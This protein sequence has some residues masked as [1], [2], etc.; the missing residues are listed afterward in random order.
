MVRVWLIAIL[1][2]LL[3][4]ASLKIDHVTVAGT[5]LK[6]MQA[7]LA[8]VG[9]RTVYGG[10]HSNHATEMA[11]VS[12]PDGGYLELIAVQPNAEAPRLVPLPDEPFETGLGNLGTSAQAAAACSSRSSFTM[13]RTA[14]SA[15]SRRASRSRRTSGA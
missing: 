13:S 10:A 3:T 8:A 12:F 7:D 6:K 11:L 5:S 14:S 15:P 4:A 1:P 9:I 2:A